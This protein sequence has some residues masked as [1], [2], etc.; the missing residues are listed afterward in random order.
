MAYPYLRGTGGIYVLFSFH[1]QHSTLHPRS[2]SHPNSEVQS[3]DKSSPTH[4][5]LTRQLLFSRSEAPDHETGLLE[6]GCASVWN[7]LAVITTAAQEASQL[8]DTR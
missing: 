3:E 4:D 6:R 7:K 5:P 8:P 2:R 1:A